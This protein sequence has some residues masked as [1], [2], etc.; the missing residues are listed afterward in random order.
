MKYQFEHRKQS[1]AN[2]ELQIRLIRIGFPPQADPPDDGIFGTE[3]EKALGRFQVYHGITPQVPPRVDKRTFAILFPEVK[4]ETDLSKN[5]W[6]SGLTGSTLVR[7]VLTFAGG[8]VA[9]KLG[10]DPEV[11]KDSIP[12]I[13]QLV[14]AVASAVVALIAAIGGMKAAATPKAVVSGQVVPL[15]QMTPAEQDAIA[16]IVEKRAA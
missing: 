7:Y 3:T 12:D 5:N 13:I 4:M 10:L 2:R 15:K 6:I 8:I 9:A 14:G 1:E 11:V 16:A